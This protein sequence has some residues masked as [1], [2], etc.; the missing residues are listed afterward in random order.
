MYQD[1]TDRGGGRKGQQG[2]WDELSV[3]LVHVPYMFMYLFT[4]FTMIS[5]PIIFEIVVA[6]NKATRHISC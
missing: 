1:G 5:H 4:R 6:L 3:E 2:S